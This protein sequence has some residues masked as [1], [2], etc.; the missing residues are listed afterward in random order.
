MLKTMREGSAYFVKGVMLVVVITFIGTIFVV[1]GVKSAPGDLARR[2]V[3]ATVGDVEI[4]QEE[5][6]Q[7]LRR[8]IEMYKQIFGER[9]DDKMLASLNVKQ[10]VAEQ[11][12]RRQVVLQYASRHGLDVGA[13]EV[14][15]AIRQF[16]AFTGKEGFSKQRYLDLL[17]ANRLTPEW[18]ETQMRQDLTER[19]V[20]DLVRESAMVSDA[21]LREAFRQSR[22]KLTVEVVQL[23]AGEE[24]KKLADTITVALGKQVPLAAAA[25][26]AGAPAKTLGPFPLSA[27]PQDI[28]DPQ[29]FVQAASIL[30]VGETSPLV[31]GTK[32][33]YLLRLVSRE[34]PSPEEFEKERAGF[35]TQFLA[36]KRE[37]ILAD[38]L[39]EVRKSVPVKLEVEG[40]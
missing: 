32:A 24:G 27:P 11:L 5:Y 35:Q 8:Q 18:F 16:P 37:M 19:K 17:K 13:A 39:R 25:K 26:D 40:L 21:E 2:G 12:V 6:Q 10:A 28:P 15:D 9:L 14:V 23:P 33:S 29:A 34:D 7:A 36:M 20:E 3:I 1:W 31:T 22:R 38:W 30:K 4:T